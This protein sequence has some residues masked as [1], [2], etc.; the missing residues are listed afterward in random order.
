MVDE[1]TS[2]PLA[3]IEFTP[4]GSAGARRRIRISPVYLSL[5]VVATLALLVFAYLLVA[6][7]VVF[8][9]N[10][11]HA[12]IDVRGPSFHIGDNPGRKEPGTGEINY[13]NIFKHIHSKG[14]QGVLCCE[15]GKSIGGKEGELAFIE[16]YRKCDAF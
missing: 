8:R 3:A 14:Y 5:G 4:L 1:K 13:K 16:A 10:P 12:I 6:R 7:A 15:H 2:K 9:L 11:G